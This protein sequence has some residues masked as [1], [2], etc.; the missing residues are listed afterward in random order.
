MTTVYKTILDI[1]RHLHSDTRYTDY[2][3]SISFIHGF[4]VKKEMNAGHIKK[5]LQRTAASVDWTRERFTMDDR[6]ARAVEE[7]F[8]RFHDQG[9]IYRDLAFFVCRKILSCCAVA[10][11]DIYIYTYIY[12]EIHRDTFLYT[13]YMYTSKYMILCLICIYIYIYIS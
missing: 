10:F 4:P 12:I 8:I 9:L 6:C 11:S 1:G 3:V 2:K 5:Q 7:A 13:L